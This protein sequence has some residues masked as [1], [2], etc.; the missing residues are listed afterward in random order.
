MSAR[1]EFWAGVR[2]TFPLVIGA[3]P[4]AILFGALA[5]A[6]GMTAVGAAVM[7]ALVYAGSAQFIAIGLLAS[8]AGIGVILLTTLVVNLRHMLYAVSLAP[9]LARLPQWL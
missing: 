3:I 9:H 6:S 1:Q 5:Q 7:S 4:F 2:A 8:G